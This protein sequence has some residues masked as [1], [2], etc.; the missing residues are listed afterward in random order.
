VDINDC[1]EIAGIGLPPGIAISDWESA[2]HAF[3]LIPCDENHPGV[4][5]CDYSIVDA[6]TAA[7]VHAAR[8][9][10]EAA[11]SRVKL[12]P[13]EMTARYRSLMANRHGRFGVPHQELSRILT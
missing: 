7:E 8:I 12:S 3:L 13:A 6:T 11:A 9:T 5:G 1:G 4:E 2:G 10:Q